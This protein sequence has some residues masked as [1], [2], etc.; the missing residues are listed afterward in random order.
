MRDELYVCRVSL[1]VSS[2]KPGAVSLPSPC[3]F[4][5]TFPGAVSDNMGYFCPF[6]AKVPAYLAMDQG[7]E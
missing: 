4:Y 2:K 6:V 1:A 7:V 5:I 3:W